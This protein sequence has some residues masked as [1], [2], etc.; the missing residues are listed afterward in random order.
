[1]MGVL[2]ARLLVPQQGQ[3]ATR[4]RYRCCRAACGTGRGRVV[5][6]LW[7]RRAAGPRPFPGCGRRPALAPPRDPKRRQPPEA[8]SFRHRLEVKPLPSGPHS[9]CL[10]PSGFSA[11]AVKFPMQPREDPKLRPLW[12]PLPWPWG[13]SAQK[14]R[15]GGMKLS[16]PRV[17][18]ELGRC[19]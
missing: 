16:L 11:W 14:W 2:F 7:K 5:G 9:F 8:G 17:R 13:T 1:M 18:F 15:L 12:A 3:L 10:G 4:S 19:Q 6:T